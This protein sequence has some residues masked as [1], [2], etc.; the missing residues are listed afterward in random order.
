M[1]AVV[2]YGLRPLLHPSVPVRRQ[3]AGIDAAATLSNLP[4]GVGREAVTLGGRPA[5]VQ[6]PVSADS[7]RAI[8]HL[9]GGGFVVGSFRTHRAL[10][11]HLAKETGCRVFVLDYRLAPEHPYPAALDDAQAAFEELAGRFDEVVVTGDSA[12]GW[13]S[14]MLA[15][16][17]RDAG[18]ATP[19]A[20]GLISPLV[21]PTHARLVLERDDM[22]QRSWTTFGGQAFA[23]RTPLAE[24]SPA[25]EDLRDFPPTVI[26][27]GADEMLRPDSEWL[28][29]ALRANGGTVEL[30]II[31]GMWHVWH[32][33]AGL[34]SD[35]TESTRQLAAKLAS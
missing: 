16:R 26:H 27:V 19:V 17:L 3:R 4:S 20:L 24:L 9:H 2:R 28:A 10:A 35:A 12:G 33:H 13:L 34:F 31:P 18:G 23:G 11:A 29:E 30:K 25:A 22:L 14:V 8:L 32:L 5:E 7:R 15:M 6:T 21:D 1:R